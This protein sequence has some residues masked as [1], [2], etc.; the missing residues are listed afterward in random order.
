M[1]Y[2]AGHRCGLD[3]VLPWLWCRLA[4]AVRIQPL[5][6]EPPYAAGAVKK[7]KKKK[8]NTPL[9]CC[10]VE[11][12]LLTAAPWTEGGNLSSVKFLL[13]ECPG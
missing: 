1:S 6:W 13:Y 2:D 3:L 7:K 9:V 5:A 8:R 4:T 11:D 10:V 12:C